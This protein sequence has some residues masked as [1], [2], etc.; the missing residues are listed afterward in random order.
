MRTRGG[1]ILHEFEMPRDK[2]DRPARPAPRPRLE[3][4]DRLQRLGLNESRSILVSTNK[5]F[6][7]WSQVFPHAACVVT[8]IDRLVHRAEIIDI[9]AESYRLKEAKERAANKAATRGTRRRAT[10]A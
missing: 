1:K 3:L 5:Q 2:G 6:A 8:L 10:G 7:E 4:K 9:D